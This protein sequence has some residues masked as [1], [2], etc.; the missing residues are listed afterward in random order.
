MQ[1]EITNNNTSKLTDRELIVAAQQGRQEAYTVLLE[2]YR[3]GLYMFV[4]E[5]LSGI[6]NNDGSIEMA[7]EPQDICQEAFQKAFQSLDKY[8][9]KY[10]FSTWI[11]N[12]ARNIAIDYSRKRKIAIGAKISHENAGEIINI[13]DGVR[14]SP[15]EKLISAQEYKKLIKHIDNLNDKYRTIARMRFIKEY[16]YDEIALELHLQINTVKTRVKRA[17]EQLMKLINN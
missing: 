5:F 8:N 14:N 9:P 17:K 1:N 10:E 16:A 2:R 15:E 6:K 13:L 3:K 11:F 12:I 4:Q 7:E